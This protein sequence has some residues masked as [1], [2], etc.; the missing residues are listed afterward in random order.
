MPCSYIRR[1]LLP[2]ALFMSALLVILGAGPARA[3]RA[4]R[5]TPVVKVAQ[6]V[7]PAVVNIATKSRAPA[8]IFRSGDEFFDR[9][10]ED[11]FGP[12]ERESSSL[13]SGVIIDGRKGLIITNSHVVHKASEITVQLADQRTFPAE[14][15][16]AD[17]DSDLALLRIKPQ[18]A[19]PQVRLGDSSD[20]MIGESVIAIG[21]PFGLS[22]TVTQGVISA[23]G[24]KV[25]ASKQ[26]WLVDLIQTDASINPGNSGGP[27]LNV[28]G[29][30]VGINTAIYY[31]AQG[32]GFAV[33]VN[34][35]KRV[36]GD[37]IRHGEVVPVWLGL[38][39]QE[40]SPRLASHFGLRQAQGVLVLEV[41]PQSP[42]QQA[43]LKRG[44]LILALDGRQINGVSDYGA[45]L[46]ALSA[47]S[48]VRLTLLRPQG[49]AEATLRAKAF[50]LERAMEVAWHRLGFSVQALDQ[51]TAR[52][53]QAPMGSAVVIAKLRPG[54]RAA[55]IGL[56][57]GDLVRKVGDKA[58]TS[59]KVFSSQIARS[60]L[61]SRITILVQ[62][63][64]AAQYITLG[65]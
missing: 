42:A 60:R 38:S 49:Q 27:L 37:L 61:Q 12:M 64:P 1:R 28:E 55:A 20:L 4:A 45:R 23:L 54:S 48:Q 44:D 22:H 46:G 43:G 2:A 32:I 13:G 31:K 36:V 24:R 33:P 62:R 41:M 7:A 26:E 50:P 8:G 14:V 29:Q 40:V 59:L 19:L 65:H 30:L 11:F 51:A 57:P 3:D 39:L 5:M 17:P 6:E 35:V 10:F 53:H 9:F 21:N 15:V 25:R 18:G 56:L 52:R 16:G 47:G 34:R 58:T 63:G